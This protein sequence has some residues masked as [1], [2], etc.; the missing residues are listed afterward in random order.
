MS[1]RDGWN[2]LCK[3]CSKRIFTAAAENC[4]ECKTEET[5]SVWKRC[6]TC[7]MKQNKCSFCDA[8]LIE[9]ILLTTTD[10]MKEL[11]T[12]A[13][14]VA[15]AFSDRSLLPEIRRECQQSLAGIDPEKIARWSDYRAGQAEII[16]AILTAIEERAQFAEEK[17][18]LDYSV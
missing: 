17:V 7:A 11:H 14:R 15:A 18:R 13:Q 16:L 1:K 4:N 2:G 5:N 9:D 6:E 8:K 10:S 12:I 3:D